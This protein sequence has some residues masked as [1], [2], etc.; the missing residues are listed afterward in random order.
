MISIVELVIKIKTVLLSEILCLK[1]ITGSLFLLFPGCE[2]PQYH[3][4]DNY[5]CVMIHEEET[6][7]YPNKQMLKVPHGEILFI[8]TLS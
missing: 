8:P 5:F 3:H 6:T 7:Q 4:N 1:D 2:E